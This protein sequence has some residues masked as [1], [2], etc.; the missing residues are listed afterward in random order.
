MENLPRTSPEVPSVGG[1]EFGKDKKD[2]KSSLRKRFGERAVLASDKVERA[3]EIAQTVDKG[4][5][6]DGLLQSKKHAEKAVTD[7]TEKTD[8]PEV[9]KQESGPNITSYEQA[10]KE[11][12]EKPL[13]NEENASLDKEGKLEALGKLTEQR[14]EEVT[15]EHLSAQPGSEEE[16]KAEG[17][18][19]FLDEIDAQ[20]AENPEGVNEVEILDHARSAAENA[21]L[22]T[23][24]E[25][26]ELRPESPETAA[27]APPMKEVL[28]EA[29]VQAEIPSDRE[30]DSTEAMSDILPESKNDTPQSETP[31]PG[32]AEAEVSQSD[33]TTASVSSGPTVPF[34]GNPIFANTP[35]YGSTEYGE[36]VPPQVEHTTTVI[37]ERNSGLGT[38]LVVG[39]LIGRHRWKKRLNRASKQMEQ[40]RRK[41]TGEVN[42]IDTELRQ[43]DSEVR[44]M[45]VEQKR[46]RDEYAKNE[47]QRKSQP[48]EVVVSPRPAPAEQSVSQTMPNAEQTQFSQMIQNRTEAPIATA[49]IGSAELIREHVVTAE[50]QGTT[51]RTMPR[52][53]LLAAST[54][55]EI[56]GTTLKNIYEAKL[57]SEQ[58][59][60]NVVDAYEHGGD[61]KR[62]LQQELI[63]QQREFERDPH[64]RHA[65][66][67][68]GGSVSGGGVVT[69]SIAG[70]DGFQQSGP[71]EG[72]KH[73]DAAAS[74]DA[75]HGTKPLSWPTQFDGGV[76]LGAGLLLVI[77]IILVL[78]L[79]NS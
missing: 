43:R 22:F 40:V 35:P 62:V 34:G 46:L 76:L 16:V 13:I 8:I 37:H 1:G 41:L 63:E 67:P 28:P 25:V 20:L 38:G 14:R 6:F 39:Y 29:D 45:A 15:A 30:D 4:H 75:Q 71:K 51:A 42:R 31:R 26:V 72:D 12:A 78:L 48:A 53:E 23:P 3:R 2:E 24:G 9:P 11:K 79:L 58:G 33:T 56:E 59:L 66:I 64:L 17:S 68:G 7:S 73:P 57:I 36:P 21:L 74:S 32:L 54:Q 70:A 77:V 55:I 27:E 50:A 5:F 52:A 69:G 65:D 47:Q 18:E 49:A 60:R 19:R 10:S 44:T 61:V